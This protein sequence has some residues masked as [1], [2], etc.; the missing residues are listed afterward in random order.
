MSRKKMKEK[1]SFE[2]GKELAEYK[3]IEAYNAESLAKWQDGIK[4][5]IHVDKEN[6]FAKDLFHTC[7]YGN[8]YV[9]MITASVIVSLIMVASLWLMVKSGITISKEAV[10]TIVIANFCITGIFCEPV[11]RNKNFV[12]AVMKTVSPAEYAKYEKK[13]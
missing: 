4:S 3:K 11:G 8:R 2:Y 12:R 1:Y 10:S 5:R 7:S 9:S 13:F 6:E